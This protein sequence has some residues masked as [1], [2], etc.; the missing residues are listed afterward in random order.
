MNRVIAPWLLAFLAAPL[1]SCGTAAT[2]STPS[3]SPDA[4]ASV[5]PAGDA[6]VDPGLTLDAPDAS[7]QTSD[8]FAA[9]ELLGRPTA[10]S[11]TVSV[12][13][14]KALDVLVEYGPEGTIGANHTAMQALAAGKPA[15]FVLDGLA[16]NSR[17]AYRLRWRNPGDASFA[18]GPTRHAQTQRPAGSTFRFTLQADSHLDENS[19]LAQYQR[20]LGNIAAD[21]PDFHIDLGDTFMCEKH[22]KP[23]DAVVAMCPDAA[24]VNARYVYERG[25]FG[26]AAHSSALFL[27]NGNH[28]GELGFLVSS[29][30]NEVATWATLARQAY[31][32]NPTPS[33]FYTGDALAE[34]NVGLRAAWYAWT[35]GD[36]LFVA[37]DPFWNT[38]KK[39]NND[40]WVWTLGERQYR[41][42]AETLAGSSAKFKFVFLHNLVGG[43]DGQMR[44]GVEAAPYFEWGGKN[45]DNSDTFAEKRPGWG[46]P[47]HQLL[48]ESH[49]SAVFHGHD[50]L[51]V[52]Q[53][54]DGVVYQEVPQPSARNTSNGA[55]LAQSYHY[56]AGTIVASAGHVRVTVAPTGVT[57]EYVRAWLPPKETGGHVNGEIADHWAISAP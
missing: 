39:T 19:D 22:A 31:F 10:T 20:T 24:A 51:Y 5:A 44:G 11:V 17:I 43:L 16:P 18:A 1:A 28:E 45:L 8:L 2:A 55:Q 50:H 13:P 14:A 52:K 42:L 47:I 25:H 53:D 12:V 57:G 21:A 26:L 41:W 23:L 34:P 32:L 48:V 30:G 9:T 3:T 35:W 7:A 46:K 49:V 29:A 33:A 37:L 56:A 6:G 4:D 15:T 36:A 40:G 27:V 38:K 54:L